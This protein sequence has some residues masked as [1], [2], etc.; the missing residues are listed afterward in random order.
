MGQAWV[1]MPVLKVVLPHNL[2]RK[3]ARPLRYSRQAPATLPTGG[4][5]VRSTALSRAPHVTASQSGVIG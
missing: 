4:G 2:R 3:L 5:A 1:R